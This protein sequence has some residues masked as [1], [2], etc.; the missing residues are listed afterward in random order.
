MKRNEFGRGRSRLSY[1]DEGT[2]LW[3]PA[4]DRWTENAWMYTWAHLACSLFGR[5]DPAFGLSAAY[6]EFANVA[7]PADVVTA[8]SFQKQ[9]GL[10]YFE[11]LSVSPGA[12]FLRVFFTG[13]PLIDVAPGYEAYFQPGTG[14]RL[15]VFASTGGLTAGVF[16]KPFSDVAN[17]KVYGLSIV[18]TPVPEDRTQDV[19]MSRSY[20]APADQRLKMPNLS[21]GATY[22]Y[23]FPA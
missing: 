6:I 16:G 12:D 2:G 5:R 9:D 23:S 14:N 7:N 11:G 3:T 19:L 17:S 15:T 4:Q 1:V 10:S 21:L 8:P 22:E 13:T 20:Y 18:A